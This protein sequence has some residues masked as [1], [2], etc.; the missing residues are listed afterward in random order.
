MLTSK[1]VQEAAI[2]WKELFRNQ[3]ETMHLFPGYLKRAH[4]TRH[5]LTHFRLNVSGKGKK[6]LNICLNY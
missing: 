2:L 5:I 3:T 4:G 6:G 1:E